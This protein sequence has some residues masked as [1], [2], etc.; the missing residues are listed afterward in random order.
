MNGDP[1]MPYNESKFVLEVLDKI[2]SV[3]KHRLMD[4]DHLILTKDN[5]M[6]GFQFVFA[7]L[8]FKTENMETMP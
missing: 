6:S 2:K 5:S 1:N 7:R 4:K 3:K 8:S